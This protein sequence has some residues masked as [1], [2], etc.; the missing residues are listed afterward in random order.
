M[1]RRRL[2][3]PL[4]NAAAYEALRYFSD[5]FDLFSD[6]VKQFTICLATVMLKCPVIEQ[7]PVRPCHVMSASKA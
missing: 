4:T 3:W 1:F 6:E 7:I 2:I 5:I